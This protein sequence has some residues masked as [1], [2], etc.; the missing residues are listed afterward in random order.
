MLA[1]LYDIHANLPALEA[2]LDDAQSAGADR[3]LLGGDYAGLGAWPIE[4][5]E[6]LRALDDAAWIRGNWER[7]LADSP[8]APGLPFIRSAIAWVRKALDPET[9][10]ELSTLPQTASIDGTLFSH[11]S[12]VSDMRSFMPE[13]A[14]DEEE[15]FGGASARRLVFGH[16]HIQFRRQ[17][18]NGIDLVNPGSVGLPFDCD[19]RAAYALIDA[20]GEVELRRI[21]YDHERTAATIRERMEGFG[22]ELAQR[23]DTASPPPRP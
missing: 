9:I 8:D 11:A 2:V 22:E 10:E 20:A 6:R 4:T 18:E 15:L 17:G 3:Y 16:T 5:L 12:P 21:E 1:V 19:T 23:I 13:P 14:E 7:W